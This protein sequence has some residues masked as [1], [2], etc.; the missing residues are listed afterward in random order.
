LLSSFVNMVRIFS[1][2]IIL[3]VKQFGEASI[4]SPQSGDVNGPLLR[5]NTNNLDEKYRPEN[6]FTFPP[7]TARPSGP[8]EELPDKWLIYCSAVPTIAV[9]IFAVLFI[10]IRNYLTPSDE[11]FDPDDTEGL[12]KLSS[13]T[14]KKKK[15]NRNE[16]VYDAMLAKFKEEKTKKQTIT[17]RKSSQ[18]R[19]EGMGS[20][21][22]KSLA[23]KHILIGKLNEDDVAPDGNSSALGQLV[24]LSTH[25]FIGSA[26]ID[27]IKDENKEMEMEDDKFQL[28]SIIEQSRED[29]AEVIKILPDDVNAEL[30]P[31][32]LEEAFLNFANWEE[33]LI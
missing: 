1:L 30:L 2:F 13:P 17:G 31:E 5:S 23:R 6:I 7:A 33:S 3:F 10:A 12:I 18:I 21:S 28:K 19:I 4:N 29:L 16:E 32:D 27:E 8:A 25:T 15:V 20:R 24:Q 22:P 11:L 26:I 9:F 14:P